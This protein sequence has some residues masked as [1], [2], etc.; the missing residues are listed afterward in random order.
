[1]RHNLNL[2][3]T[4]VLLTL[5]SNFG[6]DHPLSSQ[7]SDSAPPCETSATEKASAADQFTKQLVAAMDSVAHNQISEA[8]LNEV[9][10]TVNET[11][12]RK[13]ALIEVDKVANVYNSITNP[14]PHNKAEWLYELIQNSE[15]YPISILDIIRYRLEL[16]DLYEGA[17]MNF[18]ANSRYIRMIAAKI[19]PSKLTD[20]QKAEHADFLD[21][22]TPKN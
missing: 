16:H 3:L 4:T 12:P 17:E 1:M 18:H 8:T 15:K 14:S 22:H 11:T 2:F 9:Q 7:Q 5:S 19:F 21:K 20:E 13:A 6:A 10:Q